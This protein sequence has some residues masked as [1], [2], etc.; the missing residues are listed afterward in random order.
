MD[1]KQSIVNLFN[2]AGDSPGRQISRR[3]LLKYT[4]LSLFSF[5]LPACSDNNVSSL[6]ELSS[7]PEFQQFLHVVF[8]STQLGLEQYL[9]TALKRLQNLPD[10]EADVVASLYTRFKKRL[11]MENLLGLKSYT[12]QMGTHCVAELLQSQYA[13]QSNHALDILYSELSK[14][15][16][17]A[18]SVWGRPYSLTDMK[19]VYWDNYDQAVS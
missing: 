16:G 14:I 18:G 8:P 1:D 17:L 15:K 13:H 6:K 19:C 7:H 9:G 5:Y 12:Q 10:N 4:G 11:N 2:K 3:T